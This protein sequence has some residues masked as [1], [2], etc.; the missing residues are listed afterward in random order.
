[1][2]AA[3]KLDERSL[4]C[5]HEHTIL[6]CST[7]VSSCEISSLFP[8][9]NNRANCLG[10][11]KG[12]FEI[13]STEACPDTLMVGLLV[14]AKGPKKSLIKT[15]LRRRRRNCTIEFS[16]V[17]QDPPEINRERH[18]LIHD[19][20]AESLHR[21]P[22]DATRSGSGSSHPCKSKTQKL[23]KNRIE[24]GNVSLTVR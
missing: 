14:A 4:T 22:A 17:W 6:R 3:S 24:T 9:L 21:G 19:R 7:E 15:A 18:L 1:M 2:K 8:R 12:H 11:L 5:E 13:H 20:L 10:R 23:R 16:H